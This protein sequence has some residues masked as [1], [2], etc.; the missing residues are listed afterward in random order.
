MSRNS[1][2]PLSIRSDPAPVIALS[3][4]G[5]GHFRQ[6]L[7]LK[8]L[9]SR[10][11]HFFITEDTVLARSIAKQEDMEFVP[12]FALGQRRI[13]KLGA[14]I[15]SAITSAWTSLRTIVRRRPDVI[16]TTGAG[17]QVFVVL[18]AR[19]MG[20]KVILI[21]SFARFQAPSAFARLAGP[22]AHLRIAQS[23]Q[24]GARWGGARVFDP[25]RRVDQPEGG[26]AEE[27]APADAKE[28]LLFA[29]VGAIL[30][31]DRLSRQIVDLKQRGVIAERVIL[32]TGR[33]AETF[34]EVPGLTIVPELPF[35]EVQ[36]IL[37][38]A[39]LVVSHAGSGS[40]I[41][42]L[43]HK[44][45]AVAVPRRVDCQDSYDD[46]QVEIADNFAQRGLIQV[47]QDTESLAAALDR[48]RAANATP[49]TMDHSALIAFLEE[50]LAGYFPES[51]LPGKS[52]PVR[53]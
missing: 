22:L 47:A 28:D 6:L 24:A 34:P 36:A 40:L 42:A 50:K 19:L 15:A 33:T 32:Q 29:T 51:D 1:L 13:G 41:T 11:P 27:G 49:V 46:H 35:D 20:A 17:S 8:P 37:A 52:V 4:S 38:R 3:A 43:S 45:R 31:F 44:C 53:G 14:M 12:H 26:Q 18:W 39:S 30:P 7:D 21:D 25:L 5:G 16:I 9:W 48:A 10:Y 2:K 23:A